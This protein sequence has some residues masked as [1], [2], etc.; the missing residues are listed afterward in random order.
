[1]G[2]HILGIANEN[3][4]KVTFLCLK[5]GRYWQ[6]VNFPQKIVVLPVGSFALGQYLIL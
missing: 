4:V 1:M 2:K 6:R 3:R 5:I